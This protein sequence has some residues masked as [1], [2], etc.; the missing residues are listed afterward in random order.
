MFGPI[1]KIADIDDWTKPVAIDDLAVLGEIE[2]LKGHGVGK[3]LRAVG[4]VGSPTCGSDANKDTKEYA[5]IKR[6]AT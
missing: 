2:A 3:T 4:E 5:S 1:N 6:Q